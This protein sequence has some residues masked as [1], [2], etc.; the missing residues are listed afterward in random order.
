[1]AALNSQLEDLPQP[2]NE[3][4]GRLAAGWVVDGNSRRLWDGDERLWTSSGEANW[5][6][7]L[8]VAADSAHLRGLAEAERGS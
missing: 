3:G 4:V 8:G 1:M 5:L 2:L 7:W 6:G